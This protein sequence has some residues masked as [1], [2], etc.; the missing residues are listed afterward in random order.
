M[1][2]HE[3]NATA[4]A[5]FLQDH[6]QVDRVNYPGLESHPQ[7][8]LA[9]DQMN[10]FGGMLSFEIDGGE[11]EA[12]RFLE[13]LDHIRLAVSLGGVE[14]LIAHVAT[15]S[16]HYLDDARLESMGISESLVRMSVGIE[17]IDDILGDLDRGLDRI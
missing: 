7:H 9:R 5:E 11:P 13:D 10:G 14:S 4:V 15:M 2:S 17:H 6:P 16:H 1:E 8:K 12:A 3:R